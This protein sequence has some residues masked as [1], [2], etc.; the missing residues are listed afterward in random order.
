VAT[1]AA[2][3]NNNKAH[4][5]EQKHQKQVHRLMKMDPLEGR[6][7]IDQGASLRLLILSP[8]H[9]QTEASSQSVST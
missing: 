6:T 5:K 7:K 2:W 3:R 4:L 1:A 9:R 8:G